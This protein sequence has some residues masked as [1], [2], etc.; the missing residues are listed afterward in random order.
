ML[1]SKRVFSLFQQFN[2][3]IIAQTLANPFANVRDEPEFVE[4]GYGGMGSVDAS[5]GIANNMWKGLQRSERG[6]AL[7]AGSSFGSPS[8]SAHQ[9]TGAVTA[10]G[11][12]GSGARATSPIAR[13]KMEDN[14]PKCGMGNVGA[15]SGM[16]EDDCSGMG[17]VRKRRAEREAK[18]RLEQ[19]AKELERKTQEKRK[20]GDSMDVSMYASTASTATSLTACTSTA[21]TDV[22]TPTTSPLASRSP[23]VTDLKLTSSPCS[24]SRDLRAAPPC[25]VAGE[26]PS[27]SVTPSTP[28]TPAPKDEHEHH[29]LT[30]V[31]LSPNM[32]SSSHKHEEVAPFSPVMEETTST[33]SFG[34]E[35]GP[36]R[37]PDE[38][39][40]QDDD[41]DDDEHDAQ[42]SRPPALTTTYEHLFDRISGER[43]PS[44]PAWRKS[45]DMWASR[46]GK[47][48]ERPHPRVRPYVR[49]CVWSE[50]CQGECRVEPCST[51]L[52][53]AFTPRHHVLF[54]SRTKANN[55]ADVSFDN[56]HNP[57]C[58]VVRPNTWC[59]P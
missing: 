21:S 46:R 14:A 1:V 54:I 13:R 56:D 16:D 52:D 6:S 59:F 24:E 28:P 22:T 15:R 42:V 34:E 35:E 18:T 39:Q 8:A 51:L 2:I 10:G 53:A 38:E 37:R 31:R 50:G 9:T 49:V 55:I 20:S 44:E 45:V 25:I 27:K 40:E 33:N 26:Q 7:L 11:G 36:G 48:I 4:W 12:R 29:V 57:R 19:D 5:A 17:W 30:A 47:H 58:F 41:D 23:S 43:L 32:S 3:P